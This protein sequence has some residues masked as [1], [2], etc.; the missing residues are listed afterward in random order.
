MD[1]QLV[2]IIAGALLA[3]A[4]LGSLYFL[5]NAQGKFTF[6]TKNG[7]RPRA[8]QGE[9]NTDAVVE[10]GRFRLLTVSVLAAMGAIIAKLW[11]M[12]MV[13]SDY[14]DEMAVKNQMRTVT[15]PA[16][17]GRILDRNGVALVTNRASLTVAAYRDLADDVIAVRHLA[18]V[19]GMPY[20]AVRR[21][22]QDY[23]Q[24][25]QS[26]HTVASDVR[27]ST[28]AYIQE[29]IDEFPGVNVVERTERLYPYGTLAAHVLGYTG[30]VTQ[31]QLDEQEKAASDGSRDQG[32]VTYSSG[33]IVGQAGVEI[34]YESLLQGIKGEQ[35]VEVDSS[36]SVTAQAGSVP[37]KA[38]SDIKLTLDLKIQ[39][40]CEQG[41][42]TAMD[43][44]RG[45]GYEPPAAAIVCLDVTNGEVLGM[46]SWPTFDP[47]V[48]VGGISSDVWSQLNS[49]ESGTPL[50]NRALGGSYMSASTI[51]PLS[52]LAGLEYGIYSST[53]TT[54]CTGVWY[55]F[56]KSQPKKC[57]LETGHGVMNLRN[58]IVHSCDPVFYD[59]GKAFFYDES[60]PEGLQEMFRRWGLGSATGIDLPS[61]VKG[62]VPDAVWKKEYFSSYSDEDKAWT[63]G[64]M[65]N[66]VIGQGDILVTPL[67]MAC[68]YAGIANGGTQYVPHVFLNAVSRDGEGDAAGYKAKARLTAKLNSE[69]DLNLV[70]DGLRGVILEESASMTAHFTNMTVQV[71]GK[72]G[73]GEKNGEDPYAWFCAYAPYEQPKYAIAAV[74]EQGGFGA[75][76]AM[77]AVRTVLGALY[78]QPDDVSYTSS[79]SDQSR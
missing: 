60:N 13:S 66:I 31:E 52:S 19:L 69:D 40:A 56:G 28:I 76:A 44:A 50:I 2:V 32:D 61:E 26:L 11:T 16:P 34:M 12:Q 47:T 4:I 15:T 36:G 62:R 14:Y 5:H 64:D 48:F 55:G 35:Q 73:T 6:D 20:M 25:A 65:S 24:S 74:V 75:S 8:S 54:D 49:E 59:I 1:A 42:Q 45:A 33:D 46:A 23:S 29:H 72:T 9:G 10:K 58:G 43:T 53:Q 57:W 21:N 18:N 3:L 39:Q 41:L 77:P 79:S 22:I 37:P 38:G 27:R 71:A 67:Q 70:R 17:R 68:V 30:T 63:A 7:T 51:K 78:D